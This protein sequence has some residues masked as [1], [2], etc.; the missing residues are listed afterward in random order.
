MTPWLYPPELSMGSEL[1]Q[2]SSQRA[3]SRMRSQCSLQKMDGTSCHG[4]SR[5]SLLT[6]H[7]MAAMDG[8]KGGMTLVPRTECKETKSC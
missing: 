3:T 7:G 1:V 5:A 2:G 4:F 6:L 8:Y